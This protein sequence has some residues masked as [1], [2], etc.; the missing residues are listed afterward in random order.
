LHYLAAIVL[1]AMAG[2]ALARHLAHDK[3]GINFTLS[4]IVRFGLLGIL[5]VNGLVLVWCNLAGVILP[6]GFI[7]FL[8]I[9]P[10]VLVMLLLGVTGFCWVTK[11]SWIVVRTVG[12][13]ER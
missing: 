5:A 11:R 1:L 10:I 2:Y 12:A 3:N 6:P 9:S 4:G 8:D 13:E 7:I